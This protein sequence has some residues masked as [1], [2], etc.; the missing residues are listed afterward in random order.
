[1][2]QAS[3]MSQGIWAGVPPPRHESY[4]PVTLGFTDMLQRLWGEVLPLDRWN[5]GCAGMKRVRYNPEA[6]LEFMPHV[7]REVAKLTLVPPEKLADGPI[8]PAA[9]TPPPPDGVWLCDGVWLVEGCAV[10]M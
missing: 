2:G 6:G 7:E 4:F 3:A 9:Q 5:P 1:M 10:C 8:F